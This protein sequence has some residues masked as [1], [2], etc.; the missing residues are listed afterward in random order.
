MY[1]IVYVVGIIILY[2][3]C[4]SSG[5]VTEAAHHDYGNICAYVPCAYTREQRGVL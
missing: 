4:T 1:R 3:V 5:A 2:H